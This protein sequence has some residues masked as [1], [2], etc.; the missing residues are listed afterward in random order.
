MTRVLTTASA[1]LAVAGSAFGWGNLVSSFPS[2][3]SSRFPNG[4]AWYTNGPS[5]YV[6]V[7]ANT[8]NRIF[9][10]TSS[11][12][13]VRS[14]TGHAGDN[15]GLAVGEIG[16]ITSYWEV[17]SGTCMVYRRDCA[18]GSTY[19][20]WSAPGTVPWGAAFHRSGSA[21]YLY[22]TAYESRRLY[23]MNALS[24]S[25]YASHSLSFK[26]GDCAYGDGYLWIT[27]PDAYL[28][29]KC[30]TTG[31]QHDSFATNR[32]GNPA[33]IGYQPGYVWVGINRPLHY[34]LRFTATGGSNVAPSSLGKVKAVF[35]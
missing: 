29:W 34:V 7:A 13:V 10:C 18:T 3:A 17:N 35:R 28:V 21:Y 8:P 23:R 5:P 31:F 26:P 12:S 11:G 30:S 1:A 32:W 16:E 33:G 9:M 14:H 6:W 22:Y 4:V 19:A 20:S 24:G 15:M 2:P 27:E 25:V